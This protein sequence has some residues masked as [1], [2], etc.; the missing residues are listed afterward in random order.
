MADYPGYP[1]N[2]HYHTIA[3]LR[4]H[5]LD[6]S[7]Q[8]R[9]TLLM[10]HGN[11]AW[12]YYY[13]RLVLA[14]RCDYRCVVPDYI[15]MGLS[16]RPDRRR[17][18]FT[19]HQRVADLEDLL[20][21]L[22][23]DNNITLVLHGWGGV[24]GMA[25]AVRHPQAVKRLIIMNTTAFHP[26]AGKAVPWQLRISRLPLLGT[27]L[28]QG[29]NLFARGAVK[30]CVKRRP[31]PAEVA[32]A[33]LAPYSGWLERLAIQQFIAD[34]PLHKEAPAWS[35]LD[36]VDHSLQ[37]FSELPVLICW[38][39]RDFIFDADFLEQ[40]RRRFPHARLHRLQELGH[41]LLEDGPEQVIPL[42]RDFLRAH[43]PDPERR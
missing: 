18:D 32:A 42:V 23:I 30:H 13:R 17:Y 29:C 28:N 1:F 38:G 7:R 43:P 10:L 14:L 22:Q 39:M 2:R 24:I 33:Y 36:Q 12:S 9:Q 34:V 20:R 31:M 21:Y 4:L 35:T 8:R 11:P 26:P 16:A 27:L 25:Y 41:Y 40:W 6:E 5:Y 3:G 15:G 37:Q 19:L